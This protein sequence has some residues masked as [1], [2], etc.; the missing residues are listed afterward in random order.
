M[1]QVCNKPAPF[2]K[3]DAFFNCSNIWLIRFMMLHCRTTAQNGVVIPQYVI[4][5]HALIQGAVVLCITDETN[6]HG[7]RSVTM[8]PCESSISYITTAS[9]STAPFTTASVACKRIRVLSTDSYLCPHVRSCCKRKAMIHSWVRWE[10]HSAYKRNTL[11]NSFEDSIQSFIPSQ[12]YRCLNTTLPLAQKFLNKFKE[13]VEIGNKDRTVLQN[14][15]ARPASEQVLN[16]IEYCHVDMYKKAILYELGRL[17]TVSTKNLTF[18][19][20]NCSKPICGS[21][22]KTIVVK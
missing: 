14:L 8:V 1:A 16:S 11:Y 4:Y 21:C 5:P 2:E 19:C 9:S 6:I 20:N 3:C 15:F 17:C 22:N 10:A 12:A 18:T 7:L 13:H